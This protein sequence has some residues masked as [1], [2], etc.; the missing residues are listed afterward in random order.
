MLK[1]TRGI[2]ETA[3][4][5]LVPQ[6]LGVE[7][8][9]TEPSVCVCVSV[10]ILMAEPFGVQSRNLVHGLTLIISWTSWMGMVIG[11]RSRSPG[12]KM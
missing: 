4:N 2:V 3:S 8:I 12:L 7:V 1:P 11:Q 9:K 5:Q 10:S 6:V